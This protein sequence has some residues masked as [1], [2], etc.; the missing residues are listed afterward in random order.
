MNATQ[1]AKTSRLQWNEVMS[2]FIV[3]KRD[4]KRVA[5]LNR[6]NRGYWSGWLSAPGSE[7]SEARKSV[8]AA[9]R[10]IRSMLRG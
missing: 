7:I 3:V 5:V 1:T 8:E 10:Q 4:G 6:D 2:G 9:K